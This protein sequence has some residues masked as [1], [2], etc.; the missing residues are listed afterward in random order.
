MG[1]ILA[2]EDTS[3]YNYLLAVPLICLRQIIKEFSLRFKKGGG[4][5]RTFNYCSEGA[6]NDSVSS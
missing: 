5:F 2:G 3:T 4:S 1:V 6:I